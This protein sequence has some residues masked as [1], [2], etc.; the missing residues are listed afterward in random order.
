[1][2]A[3]LPPVQVCIDI[4]LGGCLLHIRNQFCTGP[5]HSM[6]PG[7][8]SCCSRY[9][10]HMRHEPQCTHIAFMHWCFMHVMVPV[11]S[12][13]LETFQSV[14]SAS[15]SV[16]IPVPCPF[17][18]LTRLQPYLFWALQMPLNHGLFLS[19]ANPFLALTISDPWLPP[20]LTH[21][22]TAL[23]LPAGTPAHLKSFIHISTYQELSELSGQVNQ[24]TWQWWHIPL[25]E[26][27]THHVVPCN[28]EIMMIQN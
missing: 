24:D 19:L 25:T 8:L 22:H 23:A 21:W 4:I 20:M 12:S 5:S 10:A 6:Y 15:L 18:Q 14:K 26:D 11:L 9:T 1:M 28:P 17:S 16:C 13:E 27:G 2:S 3:Y 7:D